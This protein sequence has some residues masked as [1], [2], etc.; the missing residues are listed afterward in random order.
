MNDHAKSEDQVLASSESLLLKAGAPYSGCSSSPYCLPSQLGLVLGLDRQY[1][2]SL[3]IITHILHF[4][5]FIR[6][7]GRV[8]ESY[9]LFTQQTQ[10]KRGQQT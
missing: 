4:I 10:V 3:R 9:G 2:R 7:K 1:F 5:L 6:F 8:C